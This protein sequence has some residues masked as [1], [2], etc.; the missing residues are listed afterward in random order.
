MTTPQH[1]PP[2]IEWRETDGR[3]SRARWISPGGAPAPRRVIAADDATKADAAFHLA[4]EGAALLWRGDYHNARQMLAALDRRIGRKA[5]LVAPAEFPEAFHRERMARAQ[6]ARLLGRLLIPFEADGR[7]PLRRAPDVR[8]A[9]EEAIGRP[10]EA[11]VIPLRELLGIVGAHEWRR[12]GVP[13]AALAGRIHPRHGVFAPVRGDYVDLVAQEPLPPAAAGG[14]AFDIGAGTGVLAI[15]LAR[16]GVRRVVATDTDPRALACVREN[17]RNFGFIDAIE[18][19]EADLFPPGRAPLIV[20]NPPWLPGKP[21]SPLEAAIHDPDSRM[22]RGFL[23]GLAARLEPAGE[24]WL[25][26]SDL[27]ERLKLRTR[28]TLL[29]WIAQSGLKVIA[30]RD[31]RPT[32]PKAADPADPLHPARAAEIVSLWRLGAASEV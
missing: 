24:G 25:I 20:C 8:E 31:A 16:R 3:L 21:A 18:A 2:T 27:A 17:T 30:R 15:L 1:N 6:R 10:D 4:A 12:K 5:R 23:A 19:V 9:C 29:G 22:L 11:H 13:V 7:I 26:L 28:E 32:H 14:L